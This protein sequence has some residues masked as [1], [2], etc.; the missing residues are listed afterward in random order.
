MWATCRTMGRFM[1]KQKTATSNFKESD[2]LRSVINTGMAIVV[3][4]WILLD[5]I[6]NDPVLIAARDQNAQ[7]VRAIVNAEKGY[8]A[9]SRFLSDPKIV[10]FLNADQI[11]EFTA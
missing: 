9:M 1:P 5:F 10:R 4:A 6:K 2:K 8:S 11:Q 7:V 3:P